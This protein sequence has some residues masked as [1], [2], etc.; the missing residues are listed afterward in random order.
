MKHPITNI[1]R[2][3]MQATL[4]LVSALLVGAMGARD[5]SGGK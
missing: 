5:P 2:C 1:S 4:L 3:L